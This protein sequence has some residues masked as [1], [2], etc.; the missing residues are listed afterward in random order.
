MKI[1]VGYEESKVAEA[2]LKLGLKHA[3][4]FG[5]DIFIVTSLEQS[6]TLKKEDIDKAES[7]LEN[8]R[9]S[10]T[11]DDIACETRAIVSY[12]PPGEDLV[13][14]AKE[15]DIDEI[16][17]GVKRRSKVG[18]LVFGSNAQYVILEASCPVVSVK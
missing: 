16:I 10:F 18:K 2:A 12:Q 6:P 17:I 3:K 8:I 4:A 5:A 13:N 15:N 9:K 7:K 11:A 1:L 14:L